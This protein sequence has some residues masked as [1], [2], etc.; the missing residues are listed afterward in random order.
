MLSVVWLEVVV[1]EYAKFAVAVNTM[2]TTTNDFINFIFSDFKMFNEKNKR[3][4]VL[5]AK[6]Y[7][8]VKQFLAVAKSQEQ[9]VM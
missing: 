2:K 1:C 9:I 5:G 8:I 7:K 4:E 3:S 6:S